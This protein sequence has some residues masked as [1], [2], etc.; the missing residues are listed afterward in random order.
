M[1]KVREAVS[2]DC[3]K[4]VY[5]DWNRE[6]SLRHIRLLYHPDPFLKK[7]SG[8]FKRMQES[9]S[10]VINFYTLRRQEKKPIPELIFSSLLHLLSYLEERGDSIFLLG[11]QVQQCETVYINC[12]HTFP[13]LKILG[14]HPS[15]NSENQN[16]PVLAALQKLCPSLLFLGSN[17]HDGDAWIYRNRAQLP[18]SM[19][20]W[21]P[22][23]FLRM[24]RSG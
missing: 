14:R 23:C 3:L 10:D 17:M 7:L 16:K 18:A 22:S 2:T 4:S 5:E 1:V 11:G 12:K 6:R 20:I 9:C 24:T 13:R 19:C 8:S 21:L 15:V